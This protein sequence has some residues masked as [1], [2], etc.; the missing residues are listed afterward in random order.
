MPFGLGFPQ[1]L[2]ETEFPRVLRYGGMRDQ[3][4]ASL[5]ES[6]GP[7]ICVRWP[8]KG[9]RQSRQSEGLVEV[10]GSDGTRTRGLLRNRRSNPLNYAPA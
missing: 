6:R 5:Y 9:H 7:V 4:P 8:E 1:E 3:I 10:R 2:Y